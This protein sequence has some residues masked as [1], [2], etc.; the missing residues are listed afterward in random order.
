LHGLWKPAGPI[1]EGQV[2]YISGDTLLILAV[3]GGETRGIS[4]M[5]DSRA[6]S[7]T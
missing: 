6:D 4:L 7:A 1:P 3:P 2:R 5:P